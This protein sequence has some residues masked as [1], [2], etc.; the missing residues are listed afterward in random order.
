M[1][2]E[3]GSR[4]GTEISEE[5]QIDRKLADV[6]LRD[7]LIEAVK[8][9]TRCRKLSERFADEGMESVSH[10]IEVAVSAKWLR[11]RVAVKGIS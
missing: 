4:Y 2:S 7:D 3:M 10:V 9:I 1:I 6:K 11:T 8:E 5:K